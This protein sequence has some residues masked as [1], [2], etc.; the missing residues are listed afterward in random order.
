MATGCR[1]CPI[2]KHQQQ[3]LELELELELKRFDLQQNEM[4]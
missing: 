4:K 2:I 1:S 3:Q